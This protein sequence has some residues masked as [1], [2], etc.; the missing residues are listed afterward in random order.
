MINLGEIM[1]NTIEHIYDY[2][3][4]WIRGERN[5]AF[6]GNSGM[7]LNLRKRELPA[8]VHFRNK[9]NQKANNGDVVCVV[10]SYDPANTDCGTKDAAQL[11]IRSGKK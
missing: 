4:Y 6:D 9:L 1:A 11:L 7:L 5:L 10:P 8:I 3:S 2:H